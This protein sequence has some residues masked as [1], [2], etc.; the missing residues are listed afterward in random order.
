MAEDERRNVGLLNA[1]WETCPGLP[2][3]SNL[4]TGANQEQINPDVQNR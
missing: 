1:L 4:G 3:I 2:T